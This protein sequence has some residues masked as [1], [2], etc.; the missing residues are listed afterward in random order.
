MN[1]V[2]EALAILE[3]ALQQER[4]NDVQELV[5]RQ[6]WEKKTY[7]EIAESLDYDADYIKNVGAGLW[8]LLSKS[9]GKKVT[10]S[11]LRSVLR[12][13][14]QQLVS[15]PLVA[16]NISA[17]A[18]N[19]QLNPLRLAPNSVNF[20]QDTANNCQDWGESVDVSVF[21][22]RTEE[23][24]ELKQ[25]I[26]EDRCRLVALLGMGGIGKTTLS[27]ALAKQI[28][29]E[30]DYLIWKS[31]R[32]APPVEDILE[33][34]TQ[35]FSNDQE[36][37]LPNTVE[38]GITKLI[39]YLCQY[40]CLLVLDN[41]ESI[42]SSSERAGYYLQGYEG[43][44]QL[45]KRI[46]EVPHQSC[47]ML[48]SREKPQEIAFQ[49]GKTLPVR[50]L[51]LTGLREEEGQNILQTK[52]LSGSRE[53]SISL[54]RRYAG[55]PLAL[56]MVAT[57]I[58]ELF[59]GNIQE[60]LKHGTAV[61]GEI[62]ELL[63]QQFNRLSDLEKQIM[64]WLAISRELVL[65]A[66]LQDDITPPVSK[67]ELLEALKSLR[68]RSL[69]ENNSAEF[70]QQPVV[71]EYM[72]E[73]LTEHIY[74]EIITEKITL[75]ISHALIK[76]QAKDY[77][78]ESQVRIIL[79]PIAERLRTTFRA[80]KDIE[81]K[82][83]RIL[84][85]IREEFFALPG[86]GCGN[87]INLSLQLEIDLTGY[88]F[89]SLTVWQ[90]YLQNTSLHHVN[91]AHSNLAKS[92][93]FQTSGGILSVAFDLNNKLL[94]TG[95]NNS[96]IHLRQ[97]ADGRQIFTLRG[98][99]NWIWSVTFS[100][101]SQIL[102]SGSEDRTIRLWD[103]R[104]GECLKTLQGHTSRVWSVAFSPDGQLLASGSDDQ[105]LRLWDV[106]TGQCLRTLAGDHK[107]IWSVAFHPNGNT[108]ATGSGDCTVQLWD[109][110]TSQCYKVLQGHTS[111]VFSIAFSPNGQFLVSG[112][113]DQTVRLWNTSTGKCF[114]TL[115]GH[116]SRVWSVAFNPVG[117]MVASGA[118]DQT[119]RLWDTRTG[120]CRKTL[121]GHASRVWS[122]A[123]SPDGQLLASGSDDQTVRLWN[124]S[125]GEHLR[126]LTGHSQG[127]WSV[128]FSPDSFNKLR[129]K[130]I[131]TPRDS[132]QLLASGSD[133]QTVRLWDVNTGRCYKILQGQFRQLW[134]VA[135][136]PNGLTLA[137]G[138]NEPTVQLWDIDSSQL[139]KTLQNNSGRIRSVTFSPVSFGKD[140]LKGS[141][142][143]LAQHSEDQEDSQILASS[144]DDE[145]IRLW[146]TKTGECL[147]TLRSERPYEGMIISN[148]IGLTEAQKATLKDLGAIDP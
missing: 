82:L 43:Y 45:F 138:N 105:T 137:I 128:A 38:V 21:F 95:G 62:R 122:V 125:T 85:K 116:T 8:K 81:N 20:K 3:T 110:S 129:L 64:Y 90:A 108:I 6:A 1:A 4:L 94:A 146:N 44:G 69:I 93:F 56:K 29:H 126:T 147:K 50:S 5:F 107:G 112:S 19:T 109:L 103:V 97:F 23:L 61:F 33:E 124:T 141:A 86:Y 73:R 68:Q 65:P 57:S 142:S 134:S 139:Y 47:L 52:G 35:F 144:S 41:S 55:N 67:P 113:E 26:V 11:N 76:A 31:L 27:V 36:T 117:N 12:G 89:S 140:C 87:I 115:R 51:R 74:Q 88:D 7:L 72:T 25:W 53:E 118:V 14:S 66:E 132:T 30:F 121:R 28:Q 83:N 148:V 2:D 120:E 70:T 98:H 9:L 40:R 63:A 13:E 17:A 37:I 59:D 104:T 24:R 60:F 58:Q 114:K 48:T 143:P 123:F 127:V 22:G 99:T 75:L 101:D 133:D 102:A 130:G 91:F 78:R 92:I 135:F 18:Q 77:L 100:P 84:S 71:M 46:G 136:S 10:K 34:L 16:S 80:K 39:K 42:L 79:E 32:D 119:V 131:T 145:A 106:Y 49:E 96:E 54:S 15:A 111:A